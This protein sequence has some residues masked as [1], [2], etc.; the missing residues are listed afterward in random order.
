MLGAVVLPLRFQLLARRFQFL[1]QL[2]LALP[3]IRQLRLQFATLPAQIARLLLEGFAPFGFLRQRLGQP[4][5]LGF[6]LRARGL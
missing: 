1:P 5:D 2:I 6:R 3:V 4:L